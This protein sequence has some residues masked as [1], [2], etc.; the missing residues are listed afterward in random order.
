M[1][2]PITLQD[3]AHT[4]F[5][6][7]RT[8]LVRLCTRLTGDPV[9]SEDLVQETL[10]IAWQTVDRLRDP[11]RYV[12]WV[13]GI[14][15]NRCRQWLRSR[16][17]AHAH[18]AE[19]ACDGQGTFLDPVEHV[20]DAF[21]LEIELDRAE[22][23]TLLDQA[24]AQLPPLTRMVLIERFI[25]E[26]P[27]VE[28]ARRL[29]LTEGAVE[30]RIQRGKLTLRRVLITDLQEEAAA[31][32]LITADD[33]WQ[34]TRMWCPGCG[35]QRLHAYLTSEPARAMVLRCMACEANFGAAM[36]GLFEGIRGYRTA[37]TR[38]AKW[39]HATFQEGLAQGVVA[40][41]N[42]G[43]A[44]PLQFI[45]TPDMPSALAAMPPATP[46]SYGVWANCTICRQWTH[47]SDLTAIAFFAPQVQQF[48]R[49]HPRMTVRPNHPTVVDSGAKLLISYQDP[50]GSAQ[51]DLLFD[52][53]TLIVHSVQLTT[54]S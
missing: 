50:T 31:L 20:P 10:L 21:D 37:F 40:C 9:A 5:P 28:V 2:K 33:L 19:P 47:Q 25:H 15:R 39:H 3:S 29:G 35:R 11:A 43:Q 17:R 32:G 30:Q 53:A 34:E 18:L 24:L 8:R 16:Q 14:A 23:A 36:P 12:Q 6:A 46:G 44:T 45:A 42:C 38:F 54:R 4:R 7:E 51:I 41:P 27:Q 22:L 49:A 52:S 13:E 1:S 26:S 48:W